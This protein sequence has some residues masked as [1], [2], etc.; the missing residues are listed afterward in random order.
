MNTVTVTLGEL[1]DRALLEL[2]S[3]LETG[4]QVVMG[5]TALSTVNATT[6]TLSGDQAANVTDVIEF[7]SELVLVTAKNTDPDPIYT[8][9]R[10]YY[11]TTAAVHTAGTV[12]TLNP[13]WPRF[14]V[15]DAVKRAFAR[16]EAMGLPLRQTGTFNR[17]SETQYVEM[18][19]ATRRVLRVGYF[20]PSTG[21]FFEMDRWR[22]FQDLPTTVI[23]SGCIV[24][25]PSYIADD[26]DLEITYVIPY[27]WS[28]HPAD[29]DEDATISM[30]EG[31]ED[32][33]PAYA[34]AWLLSAREVSRQSLSI[35]EEWNRAEPSRNGISLSLVRAKWQDF[36][37]TL[38]E[39]KR[40]DPPPVHRPYIKQPRI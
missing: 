21:R 35:A 22:F 8:V 17:T 33:P 16:L 29:P 19:A 13:P 14:R 9:S 24:R 18:P 40:L 38:D 31:A 28:T 37:R 7:G 12:G 25:L 11:G 39:A 30:P 27:R 3:P 1:V 4:A 10:G 23:S 20:A 36:Y 6:M 2:Q 26:D 32:L 34:V 15:A 5:S